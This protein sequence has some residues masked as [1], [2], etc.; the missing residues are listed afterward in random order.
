MQIGRRFDRWIFDS[1]DVTPTGLGLYRIVYAAFVLFVL[2][3]GHSPLLRFDGIVQLPDAFFH[4]PPGPMMVFSDFPPL[5]V[6][7]T[8][9]GLLTLSLVALLIGYRTRAASIATGVLMLIGYGFAF[10]VGKV[11]HV[12][13]FVLVPLV[14]AASNWGAAYSWDR[15]R[16]P[17]AP[18]RVHAWP[19]TLLALLLGFA[20]FTAGFSKLLGG[21]L[22]P[23]SLAT[24]GHF[25]KQ[26]FVSG[27]QD[28]LAPIFLAV[29]S[30]LF[31]KALDTATVLFEMGFLVAA[32]HPVATRLFAACAV[33]FHF[34][35]MM[36]LNISFAIHL[37][38]YAAFVNWA[39]IAQA[40]PF[41]GEALAER[42]SRRPWALGLLGG[43]TAILLAQ[44]GS[45]FF[46]LDETVS[47]TSDLTVPEVLVVSIAVLLVAGRIGQRLIRPR[48]LSSRRRT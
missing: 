5:W 15:W 38:V 11:N 43:G 35:T 40:L 4:P 23:T 37:P 25:L 17:E 45:P 44:L 29:D 26:F 31:W 7:Q 13:L 14:M 19:L 18:R 34:S 28:L 1:F 10:S 46:W 6:A 48:R 39:G 27:R 33:L 2:T 36:I 47:L 20:M 24:Q 21:W 30:G 12:M 16:R 22:D 41:D 3:P 9:S 32:F 8:T 42:A